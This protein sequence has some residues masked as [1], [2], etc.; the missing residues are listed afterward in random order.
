MWEII[1]TIFEIAKIILII[2]SFWLFVEI[3]LYS[4]GIKH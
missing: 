1:A 3:V 2:G 4:C